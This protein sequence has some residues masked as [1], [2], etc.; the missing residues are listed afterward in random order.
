[1]EGN[2]SCAGNEKMRDAIRWEPGTRPKFRA[3]SDSRPGARPS[4]GAA[5]EFHA[6]FTP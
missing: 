1:M 5:G 3:K 2:G 4:F 6:A